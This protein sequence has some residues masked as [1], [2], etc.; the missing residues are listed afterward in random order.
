MQGIAF[1]K[2][3]AGDAAAVRDMTLAAY[4]RWVAVLGRKPAPM[5]TDFEAAIKTDLIDI[6]EMNGQMVALI[7][8]Q[9][10]ADHLWVEN[11][12]V[13]PDHQGRGLGPILMARAEATARSL[14]LGELRLLTNVLMVGNLRFYASLG[15]SETAREPYREGTTVHFAKSLAM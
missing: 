13:H 4:A 10:N 1:R 6:L 12:A 3:G 5:E 11:V 2:A 9:A 8:M 14:G 7:Q 15:Y